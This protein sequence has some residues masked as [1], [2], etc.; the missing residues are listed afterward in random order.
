MLATY[1]PSKHVHLTDLPQLQPLLENN[2]RQA[3]NASVGVLEWGSNASVKKFDVIIGADVVA[4]IYDSYGLAKTIYNLANEDSRVYLACKDRLT[5]F[6]EKFESYMRGMFACVERREA[7][8]L[9]KNPGV[10][11]L[12]ASGR[13]GDQ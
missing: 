5:G 2:A 9:N 3:P 8:S 12:F 10:W 11:I 1:F 6:I 13:L 4:S 7:D